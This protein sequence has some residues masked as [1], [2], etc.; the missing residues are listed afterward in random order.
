M[1]WIKVGRRWVN[2]KRI[3]YVH[4]WETPGGEIFFAGSEPI[5]VSASELKDVLVA[6]GAVPGESIYETKPL[7]MV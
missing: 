5:K 3:E 4:C 1:E 6:I 7:E 2:L